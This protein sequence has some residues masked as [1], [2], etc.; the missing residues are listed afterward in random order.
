[1]VDDL[2]T[3]GQLVGQ[4]VREL[5]L[6]YPGMSSPAAGAGWFIYHQILSRGQ[7]HPSGATRKRASALPHQVS[8]ITEAQM[9]ATTSN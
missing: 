7:E 6:R 4:L 3:S 2:I 1:M 8:N 5:S 9:R